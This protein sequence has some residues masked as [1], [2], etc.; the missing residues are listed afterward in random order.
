MEQVGGLP[1]QRQ[2]GAEVGVLVLDAGEQV[3]GACLGQ[4]IA[5]GLGL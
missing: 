3:E 4:Q 2:G 5:C 1:R